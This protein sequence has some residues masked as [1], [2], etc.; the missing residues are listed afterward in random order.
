MPD[1]ILLCILCISLALLA[2]AV[3]AVTLW[4]RCTRAVTRAAEQYLQVTAYAVRP[5]A[6]QHRRQA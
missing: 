3:W 1:V 2:L 4:V 5:P 6:S